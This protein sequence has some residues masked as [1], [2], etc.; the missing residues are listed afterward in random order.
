MKTS[1]LEMIMAYHDGE[2]P[3]GQRIEVELWLDT[4]PEA[5][6]YLEE[7]QAADRH[8]RQ[9]FAALFAQETGVRLADQLAALPASPKRKVRLARGYPSLSNGRLGRAGLWRPV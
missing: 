5:R 7:L 2:L 8:Y 3:L 4:R 6:A 1:E 9:G